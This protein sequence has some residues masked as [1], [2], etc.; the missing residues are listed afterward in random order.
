MEHERHPHQWRHQFQLQPHRRHHQPHRQLYRHHYQPLRQRHQR[1]G[2]VDGRLPSH[3]RHRP[4]QSRRH[5]RRQRHLHRHRRRHRPAQ[6]SMVLQQRPHRRRHQRQLR[7]HRRHHRLRRQ[8]YRHHHQPLRQRH[9]Q[10]R[11]LV[12]RLQ[13][14]RRHRPGQPASSRRQQRHLQRHRGRLHPV[15]LSMVLQ[16]RLH[17]RRHQH[18]LHPHRHHHQQCRQ[19][20][21]HHYQPLRQRHQQRR[22]VDPRHPPRHHDQ[23]RQPGGPPRR[24]RHL[25]CHRQRPPLARLSMALQRCCDQRCHQRQLQPYRHH[26]RQ[27]RFLQRPPYEPGWQH[28]QHSGRLDRLV[29]QRQRRR[30]GRRAGPGLE[31]RC[32]GQAHGQRFIHLGGCL[33]GGR[34]HAKPGHPA[35]VFGGARL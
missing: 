9:Q 13:P 26:G 21:R 18:H 11:H 20:Y 17:P 12:G 1:R 34:R 27:R 6:L 33:P 3:G 7:P 25:Q 23:P 2:D 10:R 16:H 32:A 19:L 4:G 31:C 14:H 8:L 35:T 24:H 22:H 29:H 5:Q 28:H 15:E 30:P